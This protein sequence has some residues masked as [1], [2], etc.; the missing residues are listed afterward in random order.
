MI[1]D[2][3]TWTLKITDLSR[4]GTFVNDEKIGPVYENSEWKNKTIICR[5]GE[6]ETL[7]M[8]LEID[9]NPN[10]KTPVQS[11]GEHDDADDADDDDEDDNDDVND[12]NDNEKIKTSREQKSE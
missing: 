12:D 6:Q 9:M 11:K 5:L 7:E 2:A 10:D 1:A 8:C 4:N 3:G